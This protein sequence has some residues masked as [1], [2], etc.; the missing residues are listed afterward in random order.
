MTEM[1]QKRGG[2]CWKKRLSSEKHTFISE[3]LNYES[4]LMYLIIDILSTIKVK[5]RNL[6]LLF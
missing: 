5:V 3:M 4:I 6:A 1:P 2:S